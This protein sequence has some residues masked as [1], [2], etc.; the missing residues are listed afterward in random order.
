[1]QKAFFNKSKKIKTADQISA[2]V[3]WKDIPGVAKPAPCMSG[4]S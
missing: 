4:K 2:T 1:M 3:V